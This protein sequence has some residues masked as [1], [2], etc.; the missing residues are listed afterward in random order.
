MIGAARK[1]SG[2]RKI[3]RRGRAR[4]H[5]S[6]VSIRFQ[7]KRPVDENGTA[8]CH[9]SIRRS[10]RNSVLRVVDCRAGGRARDCHIL[11]NWK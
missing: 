11:F 10:R 4:S 5:A 7:R 2:D 1:F 6:F 8:G 3:R 9:C